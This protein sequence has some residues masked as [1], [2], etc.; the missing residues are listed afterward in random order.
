MKLFGLYTR[1]DNLL[2][3]VC[4]L[5]SA[6]SLQKNGEF[7]LMTISKWVL[8]HRKC[9]HL[10]KSQDSLLPGTFFIFIFP[11]AAF[12]NITTSNSLGISAVFMG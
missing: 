10:C 12:W 2:R 5:K 11:M 4:I 1:A 3:K 8:I 6:E 9:I 7:Y